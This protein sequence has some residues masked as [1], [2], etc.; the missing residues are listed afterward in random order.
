MNTSS[1]LQELQSYIAS[2]A[3][4]AKYL[5]HKSYRVTKAAV[6]KYSP[7]RLQSYKSFKATQPTVRKATELRKLQLQNIQLQK[8][9]SYKS[10]MAT[11]PTVRNSTEL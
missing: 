8:L 1:E 4:V 11:Q 10:F 3:T 6:I 5:R 7:T 9:Q 2:E